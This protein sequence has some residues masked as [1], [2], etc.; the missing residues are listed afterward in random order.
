MLR[1]IRILLLKAL[2]AE[3]GAFYYNPL[4]IANGYVAG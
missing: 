2:C 1:N 3:H 4:I